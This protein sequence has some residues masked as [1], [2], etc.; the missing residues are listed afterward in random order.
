MKKYSIKQFAKC[1]D[2]S[3]GTIRNWVRQGFLEKKWR[4]GKL[5]FTTED[6]AKTRQIKNNLYKRKVK[7]MNWK[8]KI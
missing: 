2:R 6:L 7:K 5:Y 1:S 3:V 4:L 8:K